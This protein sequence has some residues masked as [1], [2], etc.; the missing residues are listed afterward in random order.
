MS[1]ELFKISVDTELELVYVDTGIKAAFP[2]IP[3]DVTSVIDL[4]WQRSLIHR[5]FPKIHIATP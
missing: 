1:L 5:L 2:L 3:P 4:N